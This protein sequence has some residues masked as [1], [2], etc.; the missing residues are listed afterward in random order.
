MLLDCNE[1]K[2]QIL[3]EF[4]KICVFDGWNK[5][6]LLKA[7][8]NCK[9]EVKFLPL[10]FE[11]DCLDLAEFFVE[12]QNQKALEKILEIEDFTNKK[13][14]DKIRLALYARLE[15]EEN[16]QIILQRLINFYANPKN[17]T[18]LEIGA[19]PII[20]GIKSIG[21]ISDFI[22]KTINDQST[23]FNFYTKRLTLAKIIL[24]SLLVFLKDNSSDFA[25]TKK[26]IDAEIEKV[27]QFEKQKQKLKKVAIS[28]KKIFSE[29]FLDEK[30]A[31]K[32]AKEII[33][34][35]PFF[36]LTKF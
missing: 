16:N 27:M 35:L 17:F 29:N 2:Q 32:S 11:N 12:A 28:A 9:I 7:M 26:L 4:L 6:A 15:V 8:I 21:K 22:W 10:I 36:R 19:R 13:I 3:A 1:T 34:N 14:R 5:D 23:D 24:R 20:S 31:P 30:G 18:A 25:K 33:K